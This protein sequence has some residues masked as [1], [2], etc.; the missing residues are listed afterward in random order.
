M[1]IKKFLERIATEL[2]NGTIK[3]LKKTIDE[4]IDNIPEEDFN[5]IRKI[6]LAID[7]EQKI[8]EDNNLW[9]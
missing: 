5:M 1:D 2:A 7:H 6:Y 8:R 4:N 9:T 3:E